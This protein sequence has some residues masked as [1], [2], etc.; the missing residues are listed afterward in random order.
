MPEFISKT[1]SVCPVCLK[2]IE[3][4]RVV[5]EDGY[6]HMRK[7]CPEHGNF[8]ALIWEGDLESYLAW[9]DSPGE[10]APP[11]NARKVEKGCPYD[12][13]LCRDHKRESCCVLL[14]LTNRCNLQCPV[15]FA[16]AG[17]GDEKDLSL[18]DIE[19]QYEMLLECGGPFN[20]QLSGGEPTLRE[21]LAE[22]IA[23]GRDKGFSFFQLN[24]NGLRI[25]EEKGY[26]EFLRDAGVSCVF[27]QFDGLRDSTYEILRG[28]P[29]LEIKLEAIERCAKV[30][31]G[32]V[33]V[34][35]VAPGVNEDEVGAIIDFAMSKHPAVRG[36]HFQPISYFGRCELEGDTKITIPRMLKNI[37]DQSAGKLQAADF[38]GGGA[39]SPY[40][41]FHASYRKTA[42][43][44]FKVLPK[45]QN[46]SCCDS[47]ET[48]SFV[49]R[50]WRG[51]STVERSSLLTENSECCSPK[52][53]GLTIGFGKKRS[54]CPTESYEMDPFDEFIEKAIRDTFTVSG[55]VFQD[56]SDLDLERLR[57]CKIS[58]ADSNHGMVPFCAYNLTNILGET[59]Y[60]K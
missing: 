27:L 2:R 10:G 16:T 45:R 46:Q 59:L 6:I 40:C 54:C 9:A 7:S 56:A 55:M 26:A 52:P 43:G 25:A 8:Y 60:R 30:G 19:A 29:L 37:E 14:E 1:D 58:E 38:S 34:P 22:I 18:A 28:K 5:G 42:D 57:R 36:V 32:I 20:I 51:S 11:V 39:E 47:S 50:Q 49:A 53:I 33:F 41:S 35:T 12:C 24:T 31:L 17:E 21:D 23:V 3:A 48:R 44:S 4:E 13:G 15:C